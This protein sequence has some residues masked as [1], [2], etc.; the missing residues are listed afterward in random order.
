VDLTTTVLV[1]GWGGTCDTTAL[2]PSMAV[3]RYRPAC[4]YHCPHW[5]PEQGAK[6]IGTL[7][8]FG[9][10]NADRKLSSCEALDVPPSISSLYRNATE[11]LLCAIRLTDHIIVLWLCT[12]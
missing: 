1:G 8:V 3:A 10:H 9:G 2:L 11:N 5:V 12:I 4:V 7:L 6:P